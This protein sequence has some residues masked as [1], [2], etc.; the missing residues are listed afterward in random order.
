MCAHS[1]ASPDTRS[2]TADPEGSAPLERF[3]AAF[4]AGAVVFALL[5]LAAGRLTAAVVAL[6]FA[7]VLAVAALVTRAAKARITPR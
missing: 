1:S 6:A 3:L 7:L 4:A 5:P 2:V